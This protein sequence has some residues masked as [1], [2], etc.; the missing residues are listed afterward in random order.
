[1]SDEPKK[2]VRTRR[3]FGRVEWR[4]KS[5]PA[6]IFEQTEFG[7]MVRVKRSRK[8]PKILTFRK[9]LEVANDDGQRNIL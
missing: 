7:L 9:L 5:G 1:M 8:E 4:R 6:V 2:I 3:V